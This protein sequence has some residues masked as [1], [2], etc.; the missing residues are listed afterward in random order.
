MKLSAILALLSLV[1][2]ARADDPN[3]VREACK[4]PYAM[5]QTLDLNAFAGEWFIYEHQPDFAEWIFTKDCYCTASNLTLT[6]NPSQPA[7]RGE[8]VNFCHL[9]SPTGAYSHFAGDFNIYDQDSAN[10]GIFLLARRVFSFVENNYYQV[11]DVV[12]NKHALLYV[13]SVYPVVNKPA[14]CTYFLSKVPPVNGQGMPADV[15]ERFK[16]T[17]LKLGIYDES[18]WQQDYKDRQLYC[19]N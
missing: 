13:C 16:A 11:L 2:L 19:W 18:K 1:A 3:V 14:Y 4:L 6:Q 9:K 8:V 12:D 7:Q 15:V 17:A 5:E 10:H